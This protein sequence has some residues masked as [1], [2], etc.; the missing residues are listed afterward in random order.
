LE[1]PGNYEIL[2]ASCNFRRIF[3]G[4]D[5]RKPNEKIMELLKK[6]IDAAPIL[7]GKSNEKRFQAI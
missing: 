5:A 6:K 2:Y 3:K 4:F 7:C 1:T